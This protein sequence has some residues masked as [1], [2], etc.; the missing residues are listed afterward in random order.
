VFEAV[1]VRP[2]ILPAKNRETPALIL[3]A[4]LMLVYLNEK[5]AADQIENAVRNVFLQG[6]VRTAISAA[7]PPRG[8]S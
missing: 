6:K 5:Q 4:V 8:N 7:K 2:Q 3:S 1:M